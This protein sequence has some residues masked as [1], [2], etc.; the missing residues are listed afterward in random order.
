MEV[1]DA[2]P[3]TTEAYFLTEKIVAFPLH[4]KFQLKIISRIT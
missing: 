2:K 3:Q 4:E 1:A